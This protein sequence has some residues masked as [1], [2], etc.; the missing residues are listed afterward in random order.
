MLPR[1][2]LVLGPVLAVSVPEAVLV[3]SMPLP[4]A[5]GELLVV[6]E[7]VVVVVSLLLCPALGILAVP[8]AVL[9]VVSMPLSA[10]LGSLVSVPKA[11][12]P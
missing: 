11:V 1:F 8:K 5:L 7:A 6:P 3:A 12:L 10:A 9:V 4:M 2:F